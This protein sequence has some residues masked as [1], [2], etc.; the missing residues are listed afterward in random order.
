MNLLLGKSSPMI[1]GIMT[2]SKGWWAVYPQINWEAKSVSVSRIQQKINIGAGA[3][4]FIDDQAF[5]RDE[6]NSIHPEVI[7]WDAARYHELVK[8][9]LLNP[10]YVSQ[11]SEKRRLMYIE[12]MNRKKDEKNFQ[13]PSQVMH[14]FLTIIRLKNRVSF[15]MRQTAV[16]EQAAAAALDELAVRGKKYSHAISSWRANWTE[17]TAFF[18]YSEELWKIILY[19]E[20]GRISS[21]PMGHSRRCCICPQW[22]S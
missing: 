14:K 17:L 8:H 11:E 13:E 19:N 18:Q 7:C 16:N 20:R 2:L 15:G 12:D 9:P 1:F 3:I 6:V 4:L 21:L 5:K 22:M 10:E